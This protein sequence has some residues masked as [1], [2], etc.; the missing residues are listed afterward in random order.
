M[1]KKP[2][3]HKSK[4]AFILIGISSILATVFIVIILS[5]NNQIIFYNQAKISKL[6]ARSVDLPKRS[7]RDF[8]LISHITDE[9]IYPPSPLAFE[10]LKGVL[11]SIK[12]RQPD[13]LISTGDHTTD[14]DEPSYK[15]YLNAFKVTGGFIKFPSST[16]GPNIIPFI[17]IAGNHDNWISN[18]YDDY[19]TIQSYTLGNLRFIG[20]SYD[21][22]Y[23]LPTELLENELKKSCEDG[24][25]IVVYHHYAPYGWFPGPLGI[26]ERSWLKFSQLLEKYPVILYLGGHVHQ[27][28][29][30]VIS[31]YVAHTGGITGTGLFSSFTIKNNQVNI[32]QE[33]NSPIFMSITNPFQ[34]YS[35]LDYTKTKSGN[36]KIKAY[37]KTNEGSITGIYYVFD[38]G[39]NTN[40]DR[41]GSSDNYE[42]DLNVSQLYGEHTLKVVAEHSYGLWAKNQQEITVYF[43]NNVPQKPV[44]FGCENIIPTIPQ[45]VMTSTLTSTPTP[46]NKSFHIVANTQCKNGKTPVSTAKTRLMYTI[47]PYGPLPISSYPLYDGAFRINPTVNHTL[48]AILSHWF[49]NLYIGM[50]IDECANPPTCDIKKSLTSLTKPTG[51]IEG[52]A[53]QSRRNYVN[54]KKEDL[55]AGSI[56][57][58]FEA[59]E[60]WCR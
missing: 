53:F 35:G 6:A 29:T 22:R 31:S 55:P 3:N 47:W 52:P 24:K 36:I 23:T 56:T 37:A 44:A 15:N 11:S 9:H 32:L 16:P 34:Y 43:D 2:R 10:R 33:N 25:P 1:A 14:N 27:N 8:I 45:P 50:E 40:M 46:Y 41:I 38:D 4:W 54:F 12:K 13:L 7:D 60:E 58:T 30:E 39:E 48:D 49:S 57:I 21:F 26:D 42:A 17:P 20:F 18:Q 59:P 28:R 5:Q 51:T 19:Q